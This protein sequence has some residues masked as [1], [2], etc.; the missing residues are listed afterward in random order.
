MKHLGLFLMGFLFLISLMG[1]ECAINI[2]EI[3]YTPSIPLPSS[4]T[5]T[6]TN[7]PCINCANP[8]PHTFAVTSY[9][10]PFGQDPTSDGYINAKEKENGFT[11]NGQSPPGTTVYVN[12]IYKNTT[13]YHVGSVSPNSFG[14]WEITVTPDKWG[15]DGQYKIVCTNSDSSFNPIEKEVV[16]DTVPPAISASAA[17]AK[18]ILHYGFTVTQEAEHIS[19]ILTIGEL[20]TSSWEVY[21][22][23]GSGITITQNGNYVDTYYFED[24]DYTIINGVIP[25]VKIKIDNSIS[26]D[27]TLAFD[28]VEPTWGPGFF[29]INF[30]E[31][32][33]V[34]SIPIES[35]SVNN[36]TNCILTLTWEGDNFAG[37]III[38]G[39]HAAFSGTA[40]SA[41]YTNYVRYQAGPRA[42]DDREGYGYQVKLME[43]ED[44][45]GNVTTYTED[46][47]TVMKYALW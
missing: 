23:V 16:L 18:S 33:K 43:I 30:S 46:R 20:I 6:P 1:V 34:E 13:S 29:S 11:I 42:M 4:P 31:D 47:G 15:P 21:V 26:Q 37:L 25:G 10:D 45:A 19:Y 44:L 7:T 27:E 35:S 24:G 40:Q 2:P 8:V 3:P 12:L 9:E 39:A 14:H 38:G 32:V 17:Y 41:G 36:P 5:P 22:K 28:T